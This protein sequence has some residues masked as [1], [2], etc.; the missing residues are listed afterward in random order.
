LAIAAVV[1][2]AAAGGLYL[3]FSGD[4]PPE[5]DLEATAEAVAQASTTTAPPGDS[6]STTAAPQESTTTVAAAAGIDGQWT[7]D[8]SVGEFTVTEA[9]TATFVG[10][11]VDEELSSIGATTAVGRTPGVS[12]TMSIEGTVVTSVEVVAD[13][14]AIVSD[15]SRRDGAIQRA[16]NTATNPEASFALTD[17]IDLG[18]AALDGELVATTAL[19]RLTVNGITNDISID[20]EAQLVG[21]SILI[22]GTTQVVFADY[23]VTAPTA[24]A[25]L[26][27]EDNGIIELQLWMARS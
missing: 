5:V 11:R 7:V 16:L 6:P 8:T 24:P 15:R 13:M 4:A 9:T 22:T 1:V 27:V 19:G 23:D 3:F 18:E 2:V 10:F 14:T 21:D 17:P 26:S 25:V 20:I 12:G